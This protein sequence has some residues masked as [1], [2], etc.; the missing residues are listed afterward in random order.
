MME[1]AMTTSV[2]EFKNISKNYRTPWRPG[3]S[4]PALR[5]VSFAVEPGEVF[6]LLGPNR[7]G[8]T[9]LLKIL[10]GLCRASGGEATRL[11]LP[12]SERE[13]LAKVGYM[14]E[15]QAFPRYLTATQILSTYGAFSWISASSLKLRVP[16]LLEKVGLI[17]RAHEPIS[18]FSKGMVQRLSLAQALIN[19][20]ELLVLDEPMEGLDLDARRLIHEVV[21]N[22]RASGLSVLIVSHALS[23]VAE[24]CDRVAV[25][26]E[27]RIVHLG[28][29]ES[30]LHDPL[31]GERRTI[32]Q[33]L[34]PLY[35]R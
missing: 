22:Q 13:T 10:L 7:A 30:L 31:T 25:V 14:H 24:V 28:P 16:A 35:S 2:A 26:V 6:A 17:D 8:K 29:L 33:A 27:G 1:Y 12:V 19:E 23:E 9:T 15:N 11:G 20:P 21:E 3:R 34:S 5:G 18:R 4:I 32:N